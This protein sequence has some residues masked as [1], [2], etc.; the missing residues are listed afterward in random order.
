MQWQEKATEMG[1]EERKGQ[2]VP[3]D[4]DTIEACGVRVGPGIGVLSKRE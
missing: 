4:V 1:G 3:V 2:A